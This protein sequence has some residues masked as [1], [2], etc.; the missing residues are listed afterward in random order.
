[1]ASV[2]RDR[3][4][5]R[6][7]RAVTTPT[8][9]RCPYYWSEG[10]RLVLCDSA[11]GS[12]HRPRCPNYVQS[13]RMDEPCGVPAGGEYVPWLIDHPRR[14]PWYWLK[15]SLIVVGGLL[16]LAAWELVLDLVIFR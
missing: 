7:V 15:P 5:H 13:A 4:E 12:R 6:K 1:M 16:G 11:L 8:S 14:Q 3:G 2:V 10:D 9:D